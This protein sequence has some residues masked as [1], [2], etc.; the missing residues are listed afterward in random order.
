MRVHHLNCGTMHPPFRR[1]VNGTGGLFAPATMICHCLLVE[2]DAGLVLIDSGMGTAD[3]ADPARSLGSRFIRLTRPL[4]DP[5]ETAIAQ[6]RRL[7][8][9]PQDVRHVILTH[10]DLDHAGGLAD[11]PWATVHVHAAELRAAT[12]ERPQLRYRPNQWAHRPKW[13]TYDGDGGDT[14]FAF[15]AVRPLTGLPPGFG[16]VPLFGHT[17]GHSAVAVDTGDGWLLHAGDAYFHHAETDPV[18]PKGTVFLNLF[19]KLMQADGPTRLANQ[20]RLR[21]LRADHGDEVTIISAHDPVEL[22]RHGGVAVD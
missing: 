12:G 6:V 4:A 10:L 18:N 19:Q 15:D 14:W 11:F 9:A 20:D 13:A 22:A 3:V 17:L 1:L 2:T 7:G 8:F 21:R 5:G 16:L